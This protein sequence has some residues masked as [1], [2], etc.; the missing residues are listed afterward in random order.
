[1]NSGSN[2]VGVRLDPIGTDNFPSILIDSSLDVQA[3]P[4]PPSA[5][6]L[7]VG[8]A[9][10][11]GHAARRPGSVGRNVLNNGRGDVGYVWYFLLDGG[12]PAT[13]PPMPRAP[14]LDAPGVP[15]AEGGQAPRHGVGI[16]CRAIFRDGLDRA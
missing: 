11:I 16:D 6:L 13:V 7:G 14:R 15:P 12:R 5:L 4:E 8:V 1:L 10:L 2:F 9:C 3:V